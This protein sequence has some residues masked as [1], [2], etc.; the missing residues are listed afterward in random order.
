MLKRF[1]SRNNFRTKKVSFDHCAWNWMWPALSKRLENG[2]LNY[3]SLHAFLF[4][5]LSLEQQCNVCNEIK[6]EF[7]LLKIGQQQSL[8]KKNDIVSIKISMKMHNWWRL[9]LINEKIMHHHWNQHHS[10]PQNK[11]SSNHRNCC[12][13]IDSS[14]YNWRR[15]LY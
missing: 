9:S 3:I 14:I 5:L 7:P 2:E 13:T 10:G 11:K 15:R 6:M 1:F 8:K 12:T 4:P